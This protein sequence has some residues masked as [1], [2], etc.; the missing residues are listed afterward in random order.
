MKE[1]SIGENMSTHD[2][3]R[4]ANVVGSYTI[5]FEVDLTSPNYLAAPSANGSQTEATMAS[6]R[7]GWTPS[8]F[9]KG[10]SQNLT[11]K[12]G[13]QFTVY[14][15]EAYYLKAKYLKSSTNPNGVLKIVSETV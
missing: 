5:V 9:S 8:G 3:S 12:H 6:T 2:N 7:S 1:V 10:G 13:D 15:D 4:V 14:D 11:F